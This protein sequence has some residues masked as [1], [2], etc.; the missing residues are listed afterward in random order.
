MICSAVN[1][2]R[3]LGFAT[4]FAALFPYVPTSLLP[5]F[6]FRPSRDE[7]PVTTTPLAPSLTNRDARN[8]FRIRSYANTGVVVSPTKS[9]REETEV[10]PTKSLEEVEVISQKKSPSLAFN[11]QKIEA[12][13]EHHNL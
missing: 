2:G 5:Y 1:S 13:H 9:F 8:S 4:H 12:H 6:L 10:S 7:K 11:S 3:Q